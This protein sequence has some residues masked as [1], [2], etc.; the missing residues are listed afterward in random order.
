MGGDVKKFKVGDMAGVGCMVDSCHKCPACKDGLENYCD[1]GF[2]ATYN[3]NMR[4]PTTENNTFGGYS[5]SIVVPE[6]FVLRIPPN[7]DP[8][9]AAPILC[10]GVTTFS[11]MRHWDVKKGTKVGVAGL[12]GLGHMAVKLAIAMGAEVTVLT[13]SIEKKD[14]ALELG[15]IEVIDANDHKEMR[16]NEKTLDFIISTIPQPHDVNPYVKL[17]NLDGHLVIVGCIAP[18]TKPI[19]MTKMIPDRRS[20]GS[21]LI[22]SIAETQDVLDF[23]AKNNIQPNIKIISIEKVNEAYE[24]INDKKADFR[25]VIDMASIKSKT[26]IT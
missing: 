11:P 13:T 9:A 7:L 19:D 2:L 14:Y 15:A 8:A 22:G 16:S 23:C 18:L 6:N 26:E 17:L 25:Y 20:L 1:D 12:G 10:A 24:I 5:D 4:K 21:S 3:G